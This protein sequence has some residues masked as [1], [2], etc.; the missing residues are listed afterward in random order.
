MLAGVMIKTDSDT[1]MPLF[2]SPEANEWQ[3]VQALG[4]YRSSFI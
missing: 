1:D 3:R 2:S 4:C